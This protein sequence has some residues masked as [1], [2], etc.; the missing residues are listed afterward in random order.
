MSESLEMVYSACTSWL[1]DWTDAE[2]IILLDEQDLV[3]WMD[4]EMKDATKTF[5]TYAFKSS[6]ARNDALTVLRALFYEYYLFE[7]QLALHALKPN[8]AVVQRLPNLPQSVQKSAT[9][10]AESRD[11]LSGHEFGPICVGPSSERANVLRKKCAPEARME[12]SDESLESQTVYLTSD[13][14]K[15]SAFK[16]G[17][18]YEPVARDLFETCIAEGKVFDGLGR[19]RHPTL[20]RL[21]ASPDGLIMDGPRCG[22]LVEI[23]CPPSRIIDG[24]VPIHY[25]CQMQ[26]QAEVCGADAVEYIEVQFGACPQD[27]VSTDI[28]VKSKQPWIGKV[29]VTAV[30]A[31]TPPSQYT[32]QYSPLFPNTMKGFTD[33]LSWTPE[34]I[35]LESCVWYVKD[36]FHTTVLRNRRWWEEVGQ[37]AYKEFW[38]EADLARKT[39]RFKPVAMFV[40]SASE[41]GKEKGNDR[42]SPDN[43]VDSDA[44]TN[45]A[46]NDG[47]AKR[48]VGW[49]GEESD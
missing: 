38:E 9:W 42:E 23:K 45:G 12:L 20:P 47:R 43:A 2:R 22:R 40:D 6:K 18:R 49:K 34:G 27:K 4:Q 36:W 28:L 21:G 16:W 19:I 33:C 48:A 44:R 41:N 15:L 35:I 14:G 17:W 25:Y 1:K 8:P 39:G 32:Y 11:M 46:T 7:R 5:L 37:P 10:H 26:L 31:D 13:D 24:K 30:S 3:A 29:C